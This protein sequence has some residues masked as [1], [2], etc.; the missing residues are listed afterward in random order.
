LKPD[1]RTCRRERTKEMSKSTPFSKL[2]PRLPPRGKNR[3][4]QQTLALP[5][6]LECCC[7]GLVERK[8][9]AAGY[10]V[11]DLGQNRA[12]VTFGGLIEL[13]AGSN[14]SVAQLQALILLLNWLDRAGLQK[15]RIAVS[16]DSLA[17]YALLADRN[18]GRVPWAAG[19]FDELMVLLHEFSDL[20][21]KLVDLS[22]N[23][24]AVQLAV[25]GYVNAL[26]RRRRART[27]DVIPQLEPCGP[28]QYRVGD[29]Y[30]VDLEAGTCTCPD[31]RRWHTGRFP[32]RCKHIL[33][34]LELSAGER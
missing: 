3:Q 7:H 5:S 1:R 16:L 19:R 33:A 8:Q 17:V 20:E 23:A 13:E 32:I 12:L 21:F 14:E 29:R 18:R 31:F 2:S 26:E 30:R 6:R 11:L 9:A 4:W 22:R 34:A 25:E 15:R 27:R 24:R 10:W 28:H